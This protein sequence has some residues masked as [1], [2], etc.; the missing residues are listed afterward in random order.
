MGYMRNKNEI[1]KDS[2]AYKM[3]PYLWPPLYIPFHSY[4]IKINLYEVINCNRK[5]IT[6]GYKLDS[7]TFICD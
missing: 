6:I 7:F 1:T 2:H 4:I 5:S 3:F